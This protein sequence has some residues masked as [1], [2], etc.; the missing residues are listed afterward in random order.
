MFEWKTDEE[1]FW[2]QA[3]SSENAKGIDVSHRQGHIEW[4]QVKASGISF[5]FCKAT[6]GGDFNDPLFTVNVNYAKKAGIAV[7]AYHFLRAS[8]AAQGV[9]EANHFI[10]VVQNAGGFALLDLPPVVD[11]EVAENTVAAVSAWISRVK[12]VSGKQPA[13]Y[14]YP[15][16]I[17]EHLDSSLGS[18]PL[19]YANYSE[20]Q[21]KDRGGWSKWTFLQ[22]S[23]KGNVP[24]I[25]NPVDLDV[26]DSDV[27]R[28]NMPQTGSLSAADA[29]A[30][31]A[32]LSSAYQ[33]SQSDEQKANLHRLANEMRKLSGQPV[34]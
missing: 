29:N 26:C 18:I 13:I 30:I 7:G 17:D 1:V 10:T 15:S 31:I 28:L 24:G 8:T 27:Y 21:P 25:A 6:E 14:T 3:R 9:E 20:T 32:F 16:F 5:A 23:D 12:E 34:E 33:A 11:V 19:W 2:M 4:Q 22:Y